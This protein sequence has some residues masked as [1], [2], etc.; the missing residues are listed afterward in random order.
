V[1]RSLQSK[2]RQLLEQLDLR[3]KQSTAEN[4]Y[5]ENMEGVVQQI[6]DRMQTDERIKQLQQAAERN[7]RLEEQIMIMARQIELQQELATR[8]EAQS[9]GIQKLPEKQQECEKAFKDNMYAATGKLDA[10]NRVLTERCRKQDEAMRSHQQQF[11]DCSATINQAKEGLDMHQKTVD[12]S[13]KR[14][15]SLE[16]ELGKREKVL[17]TLELKFG[18]DVVAG[19]QKT[20]SQKCTLE[21][22]CRALQEEHRSLEAR[23]S[24]QPQEEPS[25][26]VAGPIN[27]GALSDA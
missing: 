27:A 1:A 14:I 3:A 9:N 12:K 8:Q 7:E 4:K 17:K 15:R 25:A 5:R 20:V 21:K 16:A 6:K 10:E 19:A 22:L 26:A 13:S 23:C 18:V 11:E 24:Q 2:N